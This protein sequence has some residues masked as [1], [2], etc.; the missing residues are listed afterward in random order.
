MFDR[1]RVDQAIMAGRPCIAGTRIPV[2]TVVSMV[3]DGWDVAGILTEFPQLDAEAIRQAL[4]FAAAAVET[5]ELPF[6]T[7]A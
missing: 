5:R 3:A 2:A 4:R 1:I 7:S 6:Q